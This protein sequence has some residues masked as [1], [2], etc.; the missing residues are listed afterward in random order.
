MFD[1]IEQ[2]PGAFLND[3]AVVIPYS[4]QENEEE[5]LY[6]KHLEKE[7]EKSKPNTFTLPT[8]NF[9]DAWTDYVFISDKLKEF[10]P[11]TYL[12]LTKLFDEMKIEWGEVEGTKDIWIRDYMPI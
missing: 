2:I 4:Y 9:N 12:R 5:R 11:Y 1:W 6:L 10:Y 8:P 7:I 3:D